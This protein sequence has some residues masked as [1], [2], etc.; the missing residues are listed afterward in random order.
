MKAILGSRKHHS[1]ARAS[2]L[3][4][5]TAALV[6]AMIGCTTVLEEYKLTI[7]STDGG[8]V[9]EPGEGTFILVRGASLLLK[10]VPDEGYRLVSWTSDA[11]IRHQKREEVVIEVNGAYSVTAEFEKIRKCRLTVSDP[12]GGEVVK[13]GS[14]MFTYD[15]GDKVRLEANAERGF[16]FVNWTGD[17]GTVIGVN[18]ARTDII[19]EGNYSIV[20][21]FEEQTAVNITDPNLEAAVREAIDIPEGRIYPSDLDGLDELD[22]S[23]KNIADLAGL[24]YCIGLKRLYLSRNQIGNITGLASLTSLQELSLGGN[25]ITDIS[26]L[27]DLSNLTLLNLSNNRLSDIQ[28]LVNCAGLGKGDKVYLYNCNAVSYSLPSDNHVMDSI[29]EL[30]EKGVIVEY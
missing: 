21:N 7:F 27:S 16:E 25:Q 13:P 26:A 14:G 20:A 19:M 6:W 15:S 5:F 12:E 1:V 23:G 29:A 22:A 17:V 10:A 3:L 4:F 30:Q 2:I 18:A 28:A 24:E 8:S 11:N 9:I